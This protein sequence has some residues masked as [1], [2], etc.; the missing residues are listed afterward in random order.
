MTVNVE[1]P[2]TIY[3]PTGTAL[4][5]FETIFTYSEAGDVRV[6]IS[7]N[8][9]D[10]DALALDVD[11]SLTGADPETEGGEVLLSASALPPGGWDP[12]RY[13]LVL[14][15]ETALSQQT[16]Y[17]VNQ[18]LRLDLL[19]KT[20]DRLVRVNQELSLRVAL[21]GGGGGGSSAGAL[22][23]A[24]NLAD[25]LSKSTARTNLGLGSA[26]T[27]NVGQTAGTVAAGDDPRFASTA[28]AG[29]AD[30]NDY[31]L[32]ADTNYDGAF[33]RALAA[34]NHVFVP[35]NPK[36]TVSGVTGYAVSQPIVI[37]DGQALHGAGSKAVIIS[38]T[39]ANQPVVKLSGGIYGGRISGISVTHSVTPTSG[40]DGIQQGQALTDWV[41]N[42]YMADVRGV[43]NYINLNLGRAFNA[44]VHDV[45]ATG[46]VLDNWSF[47]S[48]GASLV[49]GVPQ[50]APL[51]WYLNQCGAGEAGRDDYH[52]ESTATGSALSTGISV[53]TMTACRS[54]APSR[55]AMAF[56]GTD[57]G[58]IYGVRIS[59]G[60]VGEGGD[61]GVHIDARGNGHSVELD[62]IELCG[63]KAGGS[64]YASGVYI[65]G[66]GPSDQHKNNGSV[67]KIN[68]CR[69]N[70]GDGVFIAAPK[71]Q[72]IG[73]LYVNNGAGSYAS[74][75]NAI[76][77]YGVT[78]QVLGVI[79][80][81]TGSGLQ[82]YGVAGNVDG[83]Q[84]TACDFT[85]NA[86][87]P[88]ALAPIVNTQITGCF[89]ISINT[90]GGN[91]ITG[92][93]T[94]SGNITAT[95]Y[96]KSATDLISDGTL[97]VAGQSAFSDHL[98]VVGTGT[99]IYVNNGS[100][101]ARDLAISRSA[102]IGAGVSATA[103]RL[104]VAGGIVVGAATGGYTA[105]KVNVAGA[106]QV[107]GTDQTG[108]TGGNTITGNLTVTGSITAGSNIT[109]SSGSLIATNGN[110]TASN[111]TIS[112]YNLSATNNAT[113]GN[114]VQA[115]VDLIS[116]GTLHITGQSAF[117]NHL[118]ITGAGTTIYNNTG[119]VVAQD[120]ACSR[121]LGVGTGASTVTGRIDTTSIYRAGTPL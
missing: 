91:A 15:R 10:G 82:Q 16:V 14:R 59:G 61:N 93:L 37:T 104:D 73:G 108:G 11:Y 30:V 27:R 119:G 99:T 33:Q 42:F 38:G 44:D 53:G 106:Y 90:G 72:V 24:N 12:T 111:G 98:N 1:I 102:G 34:K 7:D 63:F 113:A 48:N 8:G 4:G 77:F 2:Q 64:A 115:G 114:N 97:H 31:L 41:D 89:P 121:S 65:S 120:I 22:L 54:Y 45:V 68:Q 9:V 32:D 81:D 70:K 56:F 18:S 55:H 118:N 3:Q 66:S 28:G 116:L 29:L 26:A 49:N 87:S 79:A 78:G 58:P 43:G 19:E 69:G 84:I 39:T 51:Q 6:L 21:G 105:G 40:G 107:N 92:N 23:A 85:G 100:L 101:V 112:G 96:V 110:V 94:V 57:A 109:T 95:G 13:A 80:Y 83:M 86:V 71:C 47:K 50:G 5:P 62:Y 20:L 25:L 88:T 35:P 52:W 36:L 74:R 46:A 60:F 76:N 67:V 117:S 103:G 17:G 75:R